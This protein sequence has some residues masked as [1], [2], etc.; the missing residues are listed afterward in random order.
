MWVYQD[1]DDSELKNTEHDVCDIIPVCL[2]TSQA[3][4][5]IDQECHCTAAVS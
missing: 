2:C 4:L 3:K 1:G 5:Y